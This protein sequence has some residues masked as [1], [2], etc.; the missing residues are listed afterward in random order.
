MANTYT[1]LY[2]QLVFAVKGRQSLI[3]KQHREQL[4]QYIT[5]IVQ[6]RGQKMLAIFCMPDHIHIFIGFKPTLCLSD[7]V[8][9]I[10]TNASIFIKEKR[11]TQVK[12]EWQEGFGAFSYAHSQL[13]AVCKYILNQERN[14]QARTFQKEYLDLLQKFEVPHDERY[15]FEWIEE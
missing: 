6:K 2:V 7:L 10:K 13:N 11:F 12:F 1:Q 5:G 8:R 14:H 9:D 15:L 4:H 3:E